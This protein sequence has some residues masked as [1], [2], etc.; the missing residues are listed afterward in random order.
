MGAWRA[1]TMSG[2]GFFYSEKSDY[3][4]G[5]LVY[6]GFDETFDDFE[7]FEKGMWLSVKI[8]HTSM[9]NQLQKS[10]FIMNFM[11]N[12]RNLK[13]KTCQRVMLKK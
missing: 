8:I 6:N 7:E 4:D 9:W 11:K 12:N 3:K 10:F 13:Y 2:G 5:K 1:S